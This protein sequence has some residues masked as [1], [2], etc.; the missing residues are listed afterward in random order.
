MLKLT[1]NAYLVQCIEELP[2]FQNAKRLYCDVE[3]TSFDPKKKAFFPYSGNRICGIAVTVDDCKDAYYIPIRHTD[4]RWNLPLESALLWFR[5]VVGTCE[6]WINHNVKFDAHFAHVDGADFTGELIDTYPKSMMF[7]TDRFGHKL[8]PLLRDWC[9]LPMEEEVRVKAFLKG[10][11]SEDYADVPADILGEYACMDVIGDRILDNFMDD[12]WPEQMK[13]V[14]QTEI[15]LTPVLFDMEKKGFRS[16]KK[17]LMK[18]QYLA[19][20]RMI[21]LTERIH[22]ITQ[23]EFSNSNK[24][25]FDML[26]NQFGLPILAYNKKKKKKTVWDDN[27]EVGSPTFNKAALKMYS[28]HPSVIADPIKKELIDSVIEFRTNSQFKSL[29]LDTYL[30]LMDTDGRL[31]SNY[32]QVI[33]TGRMSCSNPNAQQL[34]KKAKSLIFPSPGNAFLSCD[35]SQIEFRLIVHYI[36]DLAAIKA[37]NENKHIDFHQWVADLCGI[38]RPAG[39]TL[40]FGMAFGASKRTVTANLAKDPDIIQHIGSQ[41]VA[42]EP[43][44]RNEMYLKLCGSHASNIY[45]TYHERLPGLKHLANEAKKTCAA[46]GFVFNAFGRRRHLPPMFARKAFN[47]VIQGSAMDFIKTRIVALA[48]R[49][50][51]YL[52]NLGIEIVANVHDEILFEGPTEV[53]QDK[54]VQSYILDV[55]EIS[56]VEFRVPLTWDMGLGLK[57]WAEAVSDEA[58]IDRESLF[59]AEEDLDD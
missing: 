45:E 8:K 49:Y 53:I 17:L 9:N 19:L 41:V 11:K 13:G 40:N 43:A 38:L 56:P 20:K 29:F 2:R 14:L 25:M 50:N 16:D 7:D 35:A 1:D 6:K 21:E 22:E 47:S 42:L 15:L 12:H 37:Y 33:R 59:E 27:G 52:R 31:H 30:E 51:S 5:D 44:E 54:A 23:R 10:I 24:W 28:I 3:T 36:N 46:R 39:K 48:P 58:E 4:K 32:N 34:N 26:I 57:S 55:L 18:E